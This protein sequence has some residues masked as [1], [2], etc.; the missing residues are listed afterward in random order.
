MPRVT[1]TSG[2]P[3]HR[4]NE[5]SVQRRVPVWGSWPIMSIISPNPA[6]ARPRSGEE[7]DSTDTMHSPKK[8]ND[9]NSGDPTASITGRR[10]GML[11][12]SSMA[13]KMPPSIDAE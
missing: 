10:I 3:P 11:T 1:G 7:P 12:A 6:A 5:S 4:Y 9:N 2:M 13:P 8:A